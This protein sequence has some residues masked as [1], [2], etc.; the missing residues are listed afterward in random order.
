M[1]LNPKVWGPHYWFVLY[2]IGFTYPETP[3]NVAKK[4]YY[5][6]VQNLSLFIPHSEIGENFSK[7]INEYPVSP[8]LDSKE[9]FIRWIHFIHNR[10]NRAM[11]KPE[12][13]LET[14]YENY[15]LKYQ[16]YEEKKE[17]YLKRFRK[18]V[19]LLVVCFLLISCIYFYNN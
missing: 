4:K 16:N 7:M 9:S 6:F 12:M 3:N 10:V 19:F 2:S 17:S 18:Y 14:A 8:Y 15:Y 5:D 11:D 13:T 1:K